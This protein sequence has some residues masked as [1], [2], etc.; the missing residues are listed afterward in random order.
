MSKKYTR[1]T[2]RSRRKLP[3]GFRG[4]IVGVDQASVQL[5]LPIAEIIAGMNDGVEALAAEAGLLVMKALLD[6]EV[7]Q[8][9]GVRYQHA[10]GRLATRW[11]REDGH[12][13]FA[14]RKAA[15]ARP[16]VRGRDGRELRLERYRLFQG[17]GRLERLIAPRVVAGVSTRDYER[18]IDDVCDGY[19]IQ[20]SSVSRHWKALSARRLAEFLERPLGGLD[21]VAL[22][23]DGIEFHQF[24]LVVALGIDSTGPKHALGLWPGASENAQVCKEL[25][26]ELVRRGF[27]A[28]L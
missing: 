11:G 8:L 28:I 14:G 17:Q 20:K 18:V 19:G 24:L 27:L 26:A 23:I 12:V 22:V 7:E 16:R 6:E 4:R 1:K 10:D 13:V 9:A 3:G 15:L 2:H 21:L 25:L 5:S